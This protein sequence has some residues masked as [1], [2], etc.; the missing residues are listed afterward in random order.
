MPIPPIASWLDMHTAVNTIAAKLVESSAAMKN[1]VAGDLEAEED[2]K[3]IR[4]AENNS[5]IKVKNIDRIKPI[6]VGGAS[7]RMLESFET[8]VRASSSL[9]GTAEMVGNNAKT[10]TEAELVASSASSRLTDMQASVERCVKKITEKRAWYLWPGHNPV[11]QLP[12]VKEIAPGVNFPLVLSPEVVEGDYLDFNF[13]IEAGSMLKMS[14]QVRL[15]RKLEH[16]QFMLQAAQMQMATGGMF[17]ATEAIAITGKDIWD[18]GELDRVWNDQGSQMAQ[19]QLGGIYNPSPA[20]AGGGGA[21]AP[22]RPGSP[23][24]PGGTKTGSSSPNFDRTKNTENTMDTVTQV[25]Y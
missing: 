25:L 11:M 3:A 5:V 6:T 1:I 7:D 4:D 20:Q 2:L 23:G 18:P 19:M 22:G 16:A 14:P 17:N 13:D 10:A 21:P 15:R 9:Q 12:M 8:L 24:M